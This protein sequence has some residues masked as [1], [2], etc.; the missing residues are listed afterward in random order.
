MVL[1]Q[2]IPTLVHVIDEAS[3]PTVLSLEDLAINLVGTRQKSVVA[4]RQCFYRPL[5]V[6][7]VGNPNHTSSKQT[8][9]RT[10]I[11]VLPSSGY[12]STVG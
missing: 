10:A 1:M 5:C 4:A 3:F 9:A 8:Y 2:S 11:N 7:C 12:L 6:V